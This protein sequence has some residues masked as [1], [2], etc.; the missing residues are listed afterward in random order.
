VVFMKTPVKNGQFS[1]WLCQTFDNHVF[2][3]FY[4]VAMNSKNL[5]H[6]CWG[7]VPVSTNSLTLIQ[8]Y[9]SPS[10]RWRGKNLYL[11]FYLIWDLKSP[12]FN[13]GQTG[14]QVS[15]IVKNQQGTRKQDFLSCCLQQSVD[16][17]ETHFHHPTV[18]L[19]KRGNLMNS[20]CMYTPHEHQKDT[21]SNE[22][23]NLN[24]EILQCQG[25]FQ[26]FMVFGSELSCSQQMVLHSAQFPFFAGMPL[27]HPPKQQ[28][29]NNPQPFKFPGLP[30]LIT[31][32]HKRY[33]F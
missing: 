5:S 18:T 6:N 3:F 7:S 26:R 9:T 21:Y 19:K 32:K 20:R 31:W 8:R 24:T 17:E 29:C 30:L 16:L 23:C 10:F 2:D 28:Q 27:L 12:F 25:N 11:F 1:I 13:L 14:W 22:S 33:W 4:N 15:T